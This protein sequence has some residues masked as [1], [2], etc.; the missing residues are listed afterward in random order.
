[1]LTHG[2]GTAGDVG[3]VCWGPE[4]PHPQPG[5]CLKGALTVADCERPARPVSAR[6]QGLLGTS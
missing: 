6:L 5:C 3:Q 1:M 4:E 2:L